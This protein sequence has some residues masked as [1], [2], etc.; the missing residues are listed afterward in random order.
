MYGKVSVIM[1]NYN[2]E[3]YLS[4][5]IESVL[6]QTYKNWELL[7]VDDCSTDNSVDVI[8][9]YCESDERIKLFVNE[10]NSGA[11]ASR[12][13][14]IKKAEGKWIAFLDSDDKWMPEKLEKQLKF[15]SDNGYK[16]SY[17]AYEQIDEQSKKNGRKVVGPKKVG[18]HKMFCYCYLGCL[19][20]MYDATDI[21][22]IQIKDEIGNGENDYALWLKIA[23]KRKCYFLNEVLAQYRV[24]SC[25]LSHGSKKRRLIKNHYKLFRI[26]EEMSAFC[27]FFCVL[28]NIFFGSLKKMFY[29]KKEKYE[30]EEKKQ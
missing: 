1:P 16:F 22:L 12:N 10:K 14:A 25:S 18:T 2:C 11:A 7:I 6:G 17:T 8:K 23:K 27:A 21:G 29:E 13:L 15:M 28:R 3:K 19:T 24:R 26:S 4:E 9:K 20:V 30:K 5:T